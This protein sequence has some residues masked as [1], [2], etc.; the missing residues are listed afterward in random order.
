MR[1]LFLML[2]IFILC[3]N[4]ASLHGQ[5]VIFGKVEE[6]IWFENPQS[7]K[8]QPESITIYSDNFFQKDAN[9]VVTPDEQ[10]FYQV[11]LPLKLPMP[12]I[13]EYNNRQLQLFLF[14]TDT[15]QLSFNAVDLVQPIE[16]GGSGAWCN[17]PLIAFQQRYYPPD[18]EAELSWKRESENRYNYFSVC[19]DKYILEETFFKNALKQ[20]N[21][22][23]AFTDWVKAE[24]FYRKAN[25]L[26][27]YYFTTPNPLDDDY[28]QF[29][30]S[31][32]F[33]DATAIVSNQYLLFLEYH[34]RHL[35]KRDEVS[36]R[37]ERVGNKIPW[38]VRGY[39]LAKSQYTGLYREKHN[40][41]SSCVRSCGLYGC[42]H[43]KTS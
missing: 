23:Q 41:Q 1:N 14:T 40:N 19:E 32:N 30:A 42:S 27:A 17:A 28:L 6:Q 31:Y 25:R 34:L 9:I 7:G 20:Q 13:M 35:S 26:S 36:E 38:V 39:E 29:A 3:F 16:L 2:L 43:D 22:P 33:N 12:L 15:L 21:Y 8:L 10:G 37:S 18:V 4:A 11:Q 24:I 5:A